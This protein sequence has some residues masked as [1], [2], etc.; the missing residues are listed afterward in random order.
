MAR[1]ESDFV[2][3]LAQDLNVSG[4][5]GV[6]FTLVRETHSALDRGALPRESGE[7]LRGSLAR[8]DSVLG[9]M[10]RPEEALEPELGE[11]LGLREQARQARDW[12]EADR[13][14][15]QLASRGIVPNHSIGSRFIQ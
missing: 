10:S 2:G 6:L 1:A 5:L 9:V 4:A 7:G 12:T 3:A 15:S 14:R 11:L 8:M 13:I